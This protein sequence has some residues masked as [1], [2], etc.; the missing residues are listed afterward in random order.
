[1]GQGLDGKLVLDGHGK[2]IFALHAFSCFDFWRENR[3][4]A[5]WLSWPHFLND[6]NY[7]TFILASHIMPL[8]MGTPVIHNRRQRQILLLTL[9]TGYSPFQW[10]LEE[11]YCRFVTL[12]NSYCLPPL[13]LPTDAS[14]LKNV[15]SCGRLSTLETPIRDRLLD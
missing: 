15:P 3:Q 7:S 10:R 1:M 12:L 5:G 6:S 4:K 2:L 9:E 14:A 8:A 13:P 11:E